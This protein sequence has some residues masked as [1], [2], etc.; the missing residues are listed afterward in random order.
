MSDLRFFADTM[1]ETI[2]LKR[3]LKEIEANASRYE[4]ACMELSQ[5]SLTDLDRHTRQLYAA[6]EGLCAVRIIML[7]NS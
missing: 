1:H 2:N 6:R 7:K 3:R 4:G 5:Q